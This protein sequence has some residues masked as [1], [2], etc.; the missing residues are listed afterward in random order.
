MQLV[1]TKEEMKQVTKLRNL[2][3]GQYVRCFM[4]IAVENTDVVRVLKKQERVTQGNWWKKH[5]T[6]NQER[7]M[8][9]VFYFSDS[10]DVHI[11]LKA[12]FDGKEFNFTVSVPINVLREVT[13]QTKL[14]D[15][16][17]KPEFHCVSVALKNIGEIALETI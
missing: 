2:F 15:L 17:F 5:I 11:E 9:N 12:T 10:D 3:K 13:K 8:I 14:S 1:L 6:T 4:S 16:I 7:E